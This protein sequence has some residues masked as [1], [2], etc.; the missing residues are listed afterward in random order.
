MTIQDLRIEIN[1]LKTLVVQ[2]RRTEIL[3]L[4]NL[5]KQV[6]QEDLENLKHLKIFEDSKFHIG[7]S[8]K[9]EENTNEYLSVIEQAIFLRGNKNKNNY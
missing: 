8:S 1:A 5:E 9:K 4:G 7:E 2:L 3:E 6:E